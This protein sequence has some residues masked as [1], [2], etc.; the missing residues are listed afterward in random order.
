VQSDEISRR[1]LGYF[2][3]HAVHPHTVV[4][5][6][7]LVSP[8]PALL[9]TVAGMVPFMPYFL[10]REPSPYARATSIQKCVRTLDIDQ[11]GKTTRHASFFQMMGNFSF[12]DYFKE[13]AIPLA[14]E[15]LT[16]PVAEGGYGLAESRL[17]VTVFQTDDEAAQIWEKQIGIPAERIQRLGMKENYWSTG[18]PG[19]C[20]PC[21]EIFYDLGPEFGEGGGPAVNDERFRE[22]WNLVFMQFERGPGTGKGDFE[23]L[24]PLPKQNID[25]GMGLER[26]AAVLQ[27]VDSVYEIDTS[28]AILDVA[29]D[30]TGVAYGRRSEDDVRLRVV[31]D[32]VKAGVM[33]LADGIRPGNEGRDYILRRLLRRATR[34]MR[35]LGA[36]EPVM[37]ELVDAT[38]T[39][40]GREYPELV[41]AAPKVRKAAVDEEGTFLATLAKG[42]SIFESAVPA[43]KASGVLAGA[44]A[45]RLHDTYGF[46]IDLTLE[47]A[48]E[49]G[50]SVDEDGF[51]ALMAEQ[52]AMA[53]ADAQAKRGGLD[54]SVWSGL[55]TAGGPTDWVAY[56]GLTTTSAVRALLTGGESTP[57]LSE[58][59]VGHVVLDRTPF[60]AESGGQE[61]DAGHLVWDGGTAD[62]L[63]VT[64]PVKGLVVHEVR[65]T[66]GELVLDQELQADVDERWRRDACQ[67]HSGTHVVH[68]ALRHVLGPDAV[69]AG[70]YNRPGYLRLDFSWTG[71]L[72][73]EQRHDVEA[74]SN[75]AVR[76]DLPVSAQWMTLA[77]AREIGALALFGETYGEQVRVIEIGGPWSRE[78]CGGT[79]VRS[80]AQIGPVVLTSESSV[81]AGA[82]RV[83]AK[84]GV[85]AFDYLARERDLVAQLTDLLKVPS[86]GL[87]TRVQETVTRLRDTERAL[88]QVR[89][90]RVLEE[91]GSFAAA[92]K[93]VFGFAYVGV[94]A[95]DGTPGDLVRALALDVRGR[96]A[97]ERPAAVLVAAGGERVVLVAAVNAAAQA[98]GLSANDLLRE[99]APAVGGKG[100]GKDD[101]AQGGG[102][103]PAGIPA[104]L[105]HAEWHVGRVATR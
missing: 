18:A 82:R 62:V 45:F 35:L 91:A 99:A 25:T 44:D 105:E 51:R 72:T 9:L 65:V 93:D 13:T 6:A 22:V 69:Q 83:E 67:A 4:P 103:D 54:T 16:K 46:P 3:D 86:D 104:A 17:W 23:V 88:A 102:T 57:A 36:Y 21:S 85:E 12:G 80:S 40:M 30:L 64:R 5:S 76:D 20:G 28:K 1:F 94:H 101:V 14:W 34:T 96:L 70:S 49:Q 42:V 78:L 29:S 47:M 10:G 63:K 75:L 71:A 97:S 60:Y 55:L 50:L 84:V 24:G 58:G 33:L 39:V 77:E 66:T 38:V 19:P 37:G 26:L 48:Q 15:L 89:A 100:G 92:A 81:G 98:R 59:Q 31:S 95:P 32:H 52:K 61:S 56:E 87:A 79:H 8:D 53:K 7:S 68:A 73:P 41:Q 11:V 74:V 43:A 27:G 90:E 2:G